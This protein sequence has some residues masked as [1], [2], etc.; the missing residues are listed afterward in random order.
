MLMLNKRTMKWDEFIEELTHIPA[1]EMAA[2][3]FGSEASLKP[4]VSMMVKGLFVVWEVNLVSMTINIDDKK[5][6]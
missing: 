1:S 3:E 6:H 4:D 5:Y 2:V